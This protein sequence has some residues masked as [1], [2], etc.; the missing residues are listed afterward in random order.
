MRKTTVL[1]TDARARHVKK[2]HHLESNRLNKFLTWFRAKR[3]TA[4]CLL[5]KNKLR[6][7]LECSDIPTKITV[8]LLREAETEIIKSIQVENYPQE[9]KL[10]A[11]T[12]GE[13]NILAQNNSFLLKRNSSIYW[14]DPYLDNA[15]IFCDGGRLQRAELPKMMKHPVIMRKKNHLTQLPIRQ[16]YEEVGH[17][18]RNTTLKMVI[19]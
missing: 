11:K 1:S 13:S 9:M 17:M 14:F 10:L 18:S 16:S 15:G 19:G 5:L 2:S 8:D 12:K 7:K 4:N 6:A 3:A